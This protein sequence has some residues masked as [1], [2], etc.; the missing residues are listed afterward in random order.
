MSKAIDDARRLISSRLAELDAEMK[1]LERAL[2]GLGD[3]TGPR[4]RRPVRPSKAAVATSAPPR[5]K[6]PPSP[7][8]KRTKRAARGQRRDQLLA[9]LKATPGAR[10][11]ELAKAIGVRPTQVSVVIAKARA[12]KLIVRRG[13]GYALSARAAS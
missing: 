2:V 10:P 5:P 12:E 6:R 13:D 8:R 7:R 9:V 4:R 3:G 1:E 11:S